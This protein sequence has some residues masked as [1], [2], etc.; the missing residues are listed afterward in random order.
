M[1]PIAYPPLRMAEIDDDERMWIGLRVAPGA[2]SRS[3]TV[4][5]PQGA[6]LATVELPRTALVY[7]ARGK[8]VWC[9]VADEDGVESIVRYRVDLP[10]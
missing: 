2:P 1:I 9:V 3:W 10:G 7:F 6:V 8:Q 4:L 5:D